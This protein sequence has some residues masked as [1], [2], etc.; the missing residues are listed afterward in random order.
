MKNSDKKKLGIALCGLGTYSCDELGPA[1]QET[2]SCYLAG[3][4]TDESPKAQEWQEKYNI[5]QNNIYD[6][7]NFDD[8]MDNDDIDIVYIVLPV[9]M[10]KEFTVRAA[11]AGKH[12]ICEKPMAMDVEECQ[13]MIDACNKASVML[14]IGYHLQFEPY[15][16][17]MMRLGQQKIY[18]EVL[19][20]DAQNGFVYK[21]DAD[22][23]RLDK[24]KAG[25]GSL[26]DMGI[27]TIQAARYVTGEE[28]IFVTAHE[29]KTRPEL[30]QEVDETVYFK[31][32][33]PGGAIANC[34]SSYNKDLN[35]L[36]VKAQNG[37]FE[38]TS[39]YRYKDMK[40]ATVD[41][42]MKFDPNVNQQALQMDDFAKCI[43]ENKPSRV[44]GEE[45]IK[46]MKVIEAVYKSISSGQKEP[47]G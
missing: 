25:G 32:E 14:S 11:K 35:F 39:A 5:P 13:E 46:D 3:I 29:E 30:F 41:G 44:S 17:E 24:E 10:H 43:L 34:V 6:Y 22:S 36:K 19:S 33:F 16:L 45:G 47:I 8:I 20:I 37:R 28:P 23:W 26:M 42:P 21:D 18:G 4:I 1:L 40:G 27:Y 15:N 7:E 38:L 12:V 9:S 2:K 31:L